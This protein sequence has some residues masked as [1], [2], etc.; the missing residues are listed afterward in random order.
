MG[1]EKKTM[2]TKEEMKR[3]AIRA[4]EDD[5]FREAMR[6]DPVKVAA[7]MGIEFTPEQLAEMKVLSHANRSVVGRGNV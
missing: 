5:S 6:A 7:P 3:I 2:A 4:I 1:K